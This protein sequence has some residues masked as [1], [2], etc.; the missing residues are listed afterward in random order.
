MSGTR[1]CRLT[2]SC[3]TPSRNGCATRCSK[4]GRRGC[5]SGKAEKRNLAADFIELF[6]DESQEV[7]LV[8]GVAVGADADNTHSHSLAHVADLVL[9][10]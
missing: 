8:T 9:E 3:P 4:A 5:T 1:T 2:L 6:G 10:P 7:P